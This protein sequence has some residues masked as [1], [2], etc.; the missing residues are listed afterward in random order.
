MSKRMPVLFSGHGSPMLALEQ[1]DA[2]RELRAVGKRVIEQFGK[3]KSAAY[4][5]NIYPGLADTS[6]VLMLQYEDFISENAGAKDAAGVNFFQIEGEKGYIYIE[7]GANGLAAL[8]LVT[9]SREE[10]LNA[11]PEPD[12]WFYEVQEMTRLLLTED[13]EAFGWRLDRTVEAV[14]L[15]ESVRLAAGIR[16]PGD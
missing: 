10:R 13:R 2:T 12:R 16:F 7:N 9:V 6:G 4:Y 5:P 1:S 3:P 11:Q 8:R 15:T 14:A